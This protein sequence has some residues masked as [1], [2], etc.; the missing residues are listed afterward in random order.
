MF[1]LLKISFIY[2]RE[3]MKERERAHERGEGQREKQTPC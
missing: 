2:L 3:R 1:I